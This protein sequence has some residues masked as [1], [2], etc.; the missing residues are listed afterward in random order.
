MNQYA[1]G[2]NTNY[3]KRFTK[4]FSLSKFLVRHAIIAGAVS[5]SQFGVAMFSKGK[6]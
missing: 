1:E 5:Y 3:P 2:S 6:D 4:L